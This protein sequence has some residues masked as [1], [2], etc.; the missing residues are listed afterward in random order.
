MTTTKRKKRARKPA[1]KPPHNPTL[2]ESTKSVE[3]GAEI[4]AAELEKF[5]ITRHK[6]NDSRYLKAVTRKR[7]NAVA[8]LSYHDS[9]A[10][11]NMAEN[12]IS[13]ARAHLKAK[14]RAQESLD[15]FATRQKIYTR[16]GVKGAKANKV[17]AVYNALP[18]S[19]PD[20][21]RMSLAFE[22]GPK[23]GSIQAR[24][25]RAVKSLG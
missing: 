16:K 17:K 13:Q 18:M 5:R 14:G 20:T 24:V 12:D 3:K 25:N 4:V 22:F 19:I 15:M 23:A 8:D 6:T 1:Q 7:D 11:E 10:F 2:E 21:K 9:R